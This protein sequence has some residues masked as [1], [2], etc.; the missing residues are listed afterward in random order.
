MRAEKYDAEIFASAR[1]GDANALNELLTKTQPDIRRY[2]NFIPTAWLSD[3][4][5]NWT[6]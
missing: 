3:M 5:G 2:I 6:V 1:L 4:L